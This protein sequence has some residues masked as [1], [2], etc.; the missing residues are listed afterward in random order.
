[1]D[2]CADAD[3]AFG[4]SLPPLERRLGYAFANRVVLR[5]ALTHSSASAVNFERLEFLGDAALNYLVGRLLFEAMPNASEQRLTLLRSN[6]VNTQALATMARELDMGAFLVLSPGERRNGGA[7]RQSILADAFEALIGAVVCDGGIQNAADVVRRLFAPR[8]NAGDEERLKDPKTRL[9][10]AMQKRGF[11][12][13]D[14]AIVAVG[15][16]AHA[17]EYT[18]ECVLRALNARTTGVGGSRR[19]AEKRAANAALDQLADT[20]EARASQRHPA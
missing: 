13:P 17:P 19:E 5:R 14:Y 2:S 6:L 1:M 10:E 20:V 12:L 8:L 9:Q 16:S 3:A 4:S 15:G 18:V 11:G 7:E